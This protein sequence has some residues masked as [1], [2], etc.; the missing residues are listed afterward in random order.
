MGFN[1][2]NHVQSKK[3]KLEVVES[4]I[5]R[6]LKRKGEEEDLQ[7]ENEILHT[8]QLGDSLCYRNA[9]KAFPSGRSRFQIAETRGD[10]SCRDT[11]RK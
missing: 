2:E 7:R 8:L 5:S 9:G 1:Q 6:N 11:M 4:R 10:F 3:E